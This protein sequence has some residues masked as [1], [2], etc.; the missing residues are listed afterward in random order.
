LNDREA[1]KI[2]VSV[3]N[4]KRVFSRMF[5][6]RCDLS[7][8]DSKLSWSLVIDHEVVTIDVKS[9]WGYC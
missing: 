2:V 9:L 4:N 6:G 5:T 3:G 8:V 1:C 7:L